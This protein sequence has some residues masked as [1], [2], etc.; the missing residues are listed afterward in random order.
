MTQAN[1]S[2]VTKSLTAVLPYTG[3]KIFFLDLGTTAANQ[4]TA[5][6]SYTVTMAAGVTDQT[7]AAIAG[8]TSTAFV[9]SADGA[10]LN[11]PTY[12]FVDDG[13]AG[14]TA[15]DRIKVSF[16]EP[17]ALQIDSATFLTRG[18]AGGNILLGGGATITAGT[19]SNELI[20]T[21]GTTPTFVLGG[22]GTNLTF[23]AADVEDVAAVANPLTDVFA[24]RVALPTSATAPVQT[25]NI[26]VQDM[27]ANGKLSVGDTITVPFNKALKTGLA[28]DA[29]KI[30]IAGINGATTFSAAV[31]GSNLIITFTA[32]NA[33]DAKQWVVGNAVAITGAG[34][35]IKSAW[36]VETG[37]MA[38]KAVTLDIA[39]VPHITA[40]SYNATSKVLRVTFDKA[41][42]VAALGHVANLDAVA[43][44]FTGQ[45][46]SLTTGY[47]LGAVDNV[48]DLALDPGDTT[49]KTI[50][51]PVS[52]AVIDAGLAYINIK[53]GGPT[54]PAIKDFQCNQPV[55]LD[56]TGVIISTFVAR[57]PVAAPVIAAH[58]TRG[59]VANAYDNPDPEGVVGQDD[60]LDVG[61]SIGEDA[62]NIQ[63]WAHA[64]TPGGSTPKLR[65]TNEWD[66]FEAGDKD[67][68]MSYRDLGFE[69][70][71][72][73]ATELDTFFAALK[74]ATTPKVV[75]TVTDILGRVATRTLDLHWT[76]VGP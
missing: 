12:T 75:I 73:T 1:N 18:G 16:D 52:N 28:I 5:G 44:G 21:V 13:T 14:V 34:S 33:A 19:Y 51:V 47:S 72:Y 64:G 11:T 2:S 24:A 23:N 65:L 10:A 41:V 32:V 4:L 43:S 25:G 39:T 46:F 49:N 58:S 15:G 3:D 26:T 76:N 35:N 27:D 37:N 48:T 70:S 55:R 62:A 31:S 45:I 53:A 66:R 40:A 56:V 29:T 9:A 36:S 17:V 54:D 74:G 20:V 59:F 8:G 42:N 22:A 7:S 57:T 69:W 60:Y 67:F 30:T 68:S 61:F 38:A 6:E 63:V 71:I 50:V